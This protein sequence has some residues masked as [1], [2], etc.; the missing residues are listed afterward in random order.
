[1][2]FEEMMNDPAIGGG[3]TPQGPPM[4]GPPQGMPPQGMNQPGG[5]NPEEVMEKMILL[6]DILEQQKLE[7]DT[8]TGVK[9]ESAKIAMMPD[10]KG[11]TG[12]T[13]PPPPPMPPMGGMPGMPGMPPMGPQGPPMPPMGGPPMGPIA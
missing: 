3:M 11:P 12:M 2:A 9:S 7:I 13:L 6:R 10:M 8:R 1:M 5:P 4:G